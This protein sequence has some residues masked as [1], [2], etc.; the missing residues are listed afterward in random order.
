MNEKILTEFLL[1][2]PSTLLY[3][4]VFVAVFLIDVFYTLWARRVTQGKAYSA[5]VY[6]MLI[7]VCS[8]TAFSVILTIDN[9]SL[10]PALLGGFIATVVAVKWDVKRSNK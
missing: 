3:L 9:I 7:Y 5:A 1:S 2:L 10:I 4:L 8:V 6:S